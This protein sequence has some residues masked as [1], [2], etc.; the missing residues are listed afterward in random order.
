MS[1]RSIKVA[2]GFSTFAAVLAV[3]MA[4]PVPQASAQVQAVPR[5]GV[6]FNDTVTAQVTVETV[7]TDARTIAVT[8]PSGRTVLMPV[9][10]GVANL[11]AIDDGSLATIT[12]TEVVTMLNL[13]QKGPG[14]QEARRDQMSGKPD[15]NDIATGRFTLTVVAVDLAKNTVSVISGNG[16]AVRT[17]SANSIAKQ[18]MLKKIKVG[19][20]VIGMTT[21]LM[22]TS[23]AK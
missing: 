18:D 6:S 2:A 21:P 7:D 23:I 19:D 10:S 14:S 12:Y 1:I 8:L 13:R 9:A 4:L 3:G 15:A 17:Y 22:V 16:G 5:E 20:V 11:G